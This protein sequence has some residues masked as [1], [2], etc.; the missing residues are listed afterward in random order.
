[1]GSR[2]DTVLLVVLIV[3]VLALALLT[4]R[5]DQGGGGADPRP[6]TFVSSPAGARALREVLRELK[7]PTARRMRPFESP[8]SIQGPL[9]VLYPMMD[10]SPAEAHALAT[11]V[12]RGGTLIYVVRPFADLSDSLGVDVTP[13]AYRPRAGLPRCR[14]ASCR[15]R[16]ALN[17]DGAT[18]TAEAGPLTAGVGVVDGFRVGFEAGSKALEKATV[19]AT[20][21]NDPVVIDYRFGKGRVIAW[22]DALP[23]V[24]AR[25]KTSR[26]AILFAR[27]AADAAQGRTLWFDEYHHGFKAGGGDGVTASVT[28][29]LVHER[30]GHAVL[31]VLVALIGAVLL[32]GRRFGRPLPPP[33]ARRRSPLEHVEALAGAYEKAGARDTAR[34]LVMAGLARR[35]GRRAPS[36]GAAEEEML[37]RLAAHPTAGEAARAVQREWRKGRAGNLPVLAREVD[38]YLDEVSR[39]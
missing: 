38:H 3:V 21:G 13:L 28:R 23:L 32:I 15:I 33:P 24:N 8:D 1:M 27:T 30:P 20:A 26:A 29:W 39:T 35:L 11:W 4:S 22:S 34:R 7:I 12:R 2:R 17:N 37:A 16:R 31:Q 19:L 14:T 9:V 36:T 10:P 6:S 25:L 18:A 5:A